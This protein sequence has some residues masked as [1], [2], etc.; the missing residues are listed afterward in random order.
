MLLVL[1]LVFYL[2]DKLFRWMLIWDIIGLFPPESK[3][4]FKWF[5]GIFLDCHKSSIKQS[6]YCNNRNTWGLME[7]LLEEQM[8]KTT[9][10]SEKEIKDK[11]NSWRDV[12]LNNENFTNYEN[13]TNKDKKKI[14]E[15]FS[16]SIDDG[17]YNSI[18]KI[19]ESF[20]VVKDK[21]TNTTNYI[22]SKI[23]E[24]KQESEERDKLIS[25]L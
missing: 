20:D 5:D 23:E 14:I 7:G 3:I 9:D 16:I 1:I 21:F 18:E 25:S 4:I 12:N 22:N 15:N 10:L 6:L 8:K 19:G 17:I 13:Y 11:I 2:I 24:A